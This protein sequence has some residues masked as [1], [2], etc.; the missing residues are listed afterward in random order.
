M[1]FRLTFLALVFCSS[2]HPA[3]PQLFCKNQ[4][5]AALRE[6]TERDWDVFGDLLY[7]HAGEVGT[8]P[9]STI[10]VAAD[11]VVTTTLNLNNL[12]FGWDF[13]FRVGAKSSHLGKDQWG[14][15]LSYTWYRTVAENSGAYPGFVGIPTGFP[16]TSTLSDADFAD[17]SWLFAAKSYKARWSLQYNLFDLEAD[18]EFE[19][20]EALEFRPYLGL[21][22]G[23]I[24][25][26]I[27]IHSIYEDDAGAPV[28]AQENLENHFWGV[29]PKCGLGSQ[30]RL[31][32]LNR[33][34]FYLF[35]D[36]SGSF[37]WSYWGL[38]DF[39]TINQINHGNLYG[40]DRQ[41]GSV[42]LQN[43]L[44][45][46]WNVKLNN[47]GMLFKARCSYEAQYWFDHLQIFNA[48]NGR[49]H[50]ALTLQGGTFDFRFH[51]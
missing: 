1:K 37:L 45:F 13:G 8:I 49:Q 23:W 28:P 12:N 19:A 29:G 20:S 11:E 2:I 43:L 26:D 50:N 42:A 46:E 34:T 40:K 22:G 51:F 7:W 32:A 14:L 38:S 47:S 18:H 25:Q 31:G 41:A 16:L 9:N 48:Y 10:A 27:A 30:W 6:P 5:V 35:G 36:L 15:S 44:G 24:Y 21:R 17:L 39:L 4:T 3:E 33:H